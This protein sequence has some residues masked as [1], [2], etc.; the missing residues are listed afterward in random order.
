MKKVVQTVV[1]GLTAAM[2]LSVPS[3]ALA[4][5][6]ASDSFAKGTQKQW[7][8]DQKAP[9]KWDTSGSV[10]QISVG[11]TGSI[12]SGKSAG[13]SV[14]N[15]VYDIQG[16]KMALPKPAS[17]VWTASV[18]VNADQDWFSS[19][20]SRRAAVFRLDLVDASGEALTTPVAFAL[21]KRS[22]AQPQWAC[23]NTELPDGWSYPKLYSGT[24]GGLITKEL[25]VEEG[26]RTL[27]IKCNKG[28]ITYQVDG[29]VLTSFDLG[30]EVY[31]S[32]VSLGLAD[33][34]NSFT[35]EF[36]SFAL[37]NGNVGQ[38]KRVLTETE[39]EEASSS[40]EES[41]K[42]R[43]A[44]WIASHTEY[45]IKDSDGTERWVRAGQ[46]TDEEKESALDKRR[47]ADDPDWFDDI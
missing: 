15:G 29:K 19:S 47:T 38:P 45:K 10:L 4:S 34:N 11:R 39:E 6:V 5:V 8:V 23:L 16:K 20:V 12:V 44:R 17:N 36:D 13:V 3:S 1:A 2:M 46:L 21:E 18:K 9:A 7:E 35:A 31:P 26:W 25:E 43:K 40:K 42:K 28:L 27:Y 32:Y 41:L 14:K 24:G 33:G 30:T 22:S 37:Y